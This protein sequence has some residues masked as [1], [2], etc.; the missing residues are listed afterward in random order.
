MISVILPTYNEKGNI[1]KLIN[2]ILSNVKNCEIMVV[3]DNSPDLTWKDVQKIK[4]KNVK[5]IRRIKEKGLAS[6]ISRGIEES[7]GNVIVWMDCDLS[8]PPSLIPELVKKLNKYDI[9]V[10]SR[11]VNGGA[12]KRK[13]IRV[14]TSRIFNIYAQLILMLRVKDTDSGFIAVKRDVF[15]KVSLS[16]EGYGEY[17][18]QFVYECQKNNFKITEVPYLFK[19]REIGESKTGE[20]LIPLLKQGFN[21]GVRVLKIRFTK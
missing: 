2:S 8:H 13:F 21:Y 6:A 19:D 16:K 4:K 20:S 14:F 5:L 10:A 3:D 18:I 12:D 7:K 17:F 15:K 9:A 11:Y 1:V